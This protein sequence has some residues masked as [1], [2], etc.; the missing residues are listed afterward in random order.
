[1]YIINILTLAGEVETAEFATFEACIL[2]FMGFGKL[3]AFASI[4]DPADKT[5]WEYDYF[6]N[7]AKMGL[8]AHA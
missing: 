8:D 3:M 2:H 7:A 4:D 6:A 5:V 1:M